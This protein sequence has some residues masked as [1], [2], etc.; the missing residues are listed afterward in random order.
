[1]TELEQFVAT[2][3]FSLFDGCCC[4]KAKN[5]LDLHKCP[6]RHCNTEWTTEQAADWWAKAKQ[7]W[8]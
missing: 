1:M 3:C 2:T 4:G 7:E 8:A 6:S 5:H